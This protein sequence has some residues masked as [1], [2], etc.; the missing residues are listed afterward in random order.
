ME[1][2]AHPSLQLLT[3]V[4]QFKLSG[5]Q[6]ASQKEGSMGKDITNQRFGLLT[7]VSE[8]PSHNG[9]A[10]WV[11][12]CECGRETICKGVELRRG[13]VKSCGCLNFTTKARRKPK[14]GNKTIGG[15]APSKTRLY[16]IWRNMIQRCYNSKA[17]SYPWYG[18]KG[19][20]VCDSWRKDFY[21]FAEWALSHGYEKNLTIDRVDV[22][23]GYSPDNCRWA[24]YK[25]QAQNRRTES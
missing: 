22:T 17:K 18:A 16:S 8:A 5:E 7:V 9:Y 13:H 21:V 1:K 14:K 15:V 25:E 19:V 6:T 12:R 11:C 20:T 10:R 4:V 3:L 24:T 2:A 23:K